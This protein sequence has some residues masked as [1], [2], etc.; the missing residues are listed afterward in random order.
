MKSRRAAASRSSGPNRKFYVAL[1]GIAVVGIV[2]VGWSI[3]RP[4]PG[5]QVTTV[6][7]TPS[8]AHGYVYG[9]PNA[10]VKILEF[11]DFECPVC[12]QFA[13][14]TEPDVRQR[15]LDTGLASLTYFDFPLSMHHNTIP[16]SNA[17]ACADDQGK[18][19][20]MHD[21][22]F[23]GQLEWNTEATNNPKKVFLRYAKELGLNTQQ[24]EQ[25]YDSQK[26]MS[27]IMGN[28]AEALRRHIDQTPTFIIGNKMIPG[29]IPYDQL[30]AYVDAAAARVATAAAA[31][32]DSQTT[33]GAP[34]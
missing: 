24:W 4:R 27:R 17:A 2:L 5:M 20:P 16:A 31:R 28:R 18:F 12:G 1:V 23:S 30:K 22:L 13:I 6:Q 11:G 26:H 32:S 25:C 15:I 10:P 33:A 21:R 7:A 8:Q 9:N 14:V 34:R 19:W 29:P 3:A